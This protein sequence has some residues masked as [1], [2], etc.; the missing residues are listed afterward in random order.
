MEGSLKGG[1]GVGFFV[2]TSVM[3]GQFANANL[4]YELPVDDT[5]SAACHQYQAREEQHDTAVRWNP[6]SLVLRS[7]IYRDSRSPQA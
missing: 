6:D 3:H 4:R 7:T 5:D 2:L 1:G